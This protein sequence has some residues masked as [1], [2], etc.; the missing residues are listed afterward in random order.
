M[1]QALPAPK[2]PNLNK[3]SDAGGT[4]IPW[5]SDAARNRLFRLFRYILDLK[6]GVNGIPLIYE[7]VAKP[8]F[9]PKS[10]LLP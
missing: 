2:E 3:L 7:P 8:Q 5:L 1:S 6:R 10:A 9:L 4:Q